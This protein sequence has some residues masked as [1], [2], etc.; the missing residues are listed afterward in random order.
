MVWWGRAERW[1]RGLAR[2]SERGPCSVPVLRGRAS[3]LHPE[4][5]PEPDPAPEPQPEP[6]PAPGTRAPRLTPAHCASRPHPPALRGPDV[7]SV[8]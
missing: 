7:G 1:H 3:N 6:D 4:P 2:Q 5:E 8:G